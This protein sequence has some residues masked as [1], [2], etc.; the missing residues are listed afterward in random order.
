VFSQAMVMTSLRQSL[1]GML[2]A[3]HPLTRYVSHLQGLLSL[4]R[5]LRRSEGEVGQPAC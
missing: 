3:W 5:R 1:L 4:L 2:A